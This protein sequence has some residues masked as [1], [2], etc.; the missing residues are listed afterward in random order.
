MGEDNVIDIGSGRRKEPERDVHG[1]SMDGATYI[2]GE[3]PVMVQP[4]TAQELRDAGDGRG[5]PRK[6]RVPMM[7]LHLDKAAEFTV[8][9]FEDG[10]RLTRR[11]WIAMANEAW[12]RFAAVRVQDPTE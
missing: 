7:G 1:I 11:E 12:N 2:L 3:G 5:A 9:E 8:A 10:S 6:L 4:P